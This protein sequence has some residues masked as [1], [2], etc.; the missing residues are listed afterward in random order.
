MNFNKNNVLPTISV[1]GLGGGGGNSV[2][3]MFSS[4]TMGGVNFV[5]ANTDIQALN[6]SSVENKIQLGVKLTKGQGAGANPETGLKAAEESADEIRERISGSDMLFISAGMGGGTGSG[7]VPLVAQIAKE[8]GILTVAVVTTP[9]YFEGMPRQRIA[10]KAITDL[11]KYCETVIV[12][13]NQNLLSISNT[14]TKLHEAFK[15]VDD[16]LYMSVRSIVDLVI[17]PGMINC[18][19]ADIRNTMKAKGRAMMGIGQAIGENRALRAAQAAINNPLLDHSSI[20]D[21]KSLLINITGGD[22]LTLHEVDEA[23]NEVKKAMKNDECVII[24]GSVYEKNADFIR[25]SLVATGITD[26]VK[27][28]ELAGG[29]GNITSNSNPFASSSSSGLSYA[30]S[31]SR[32]SYTNPMWQSSTESSSANSSLSEKQNNYNSNTDNSELDLPA[33]LRRRK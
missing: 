31:E 3:R 17:Q 29:L 11:K 28:I 5:V 16:I 22:D 7:S 4:D 18:D 12:I 33:F 26:P 8:M 6:L 25:V 20:Q 14:S 32:P 24:F 30:A 2:N 27:E 15:A 13:H 1:I 19:F 21:S 10:K 23:V 9:F